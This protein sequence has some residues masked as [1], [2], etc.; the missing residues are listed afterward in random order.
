MLAPAPPSPREARKHLLLQS[1]SPANNE[2]ELA[3]GRSGT[4]RSR[5][6]VT[7]AAAKNSHETI[8]DSFHPHLVPPSPDFDSL[9]QGNPCHPLVLS[10]V[11]ISFCSASCPCVCVFAGLYWTCSLSLPRSSV[12]GSHKTEVNVA[13]AGC[14]GPRIQ[15]TSARGVAHPGNT[16]QPP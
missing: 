8:G 16:K 13:V 2:N 3:S 6:R 12:F 4:L 14:R 7:P 15:H 5:C 9:L 1:S 10:N 11:S